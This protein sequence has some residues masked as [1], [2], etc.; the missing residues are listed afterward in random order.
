MP[1]IGITCSN[2]SSWPSSKA[3]S[4]RRSVAACTTD[5]TATSDGGALHS[6]GMTQLS[7]IEPATDSGVFV[8][9]TANGSRYVVV[10]VD[11]RWWV[12]RSPALGAPPLWLDKG[13]GINRLEAQVGLPLR[14]TRSGGYLDG[15]VW[16]VGGEIEGIATALPGDLNEAE[17]RFA[18]DAG[19]FS[20]RTGLAQ[21]RPSDDP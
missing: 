5:A 15:D 21:R 12:R 2:S 14:C 3:A 19:A 6:G 1:L 17:L 4:T 13:S 16:A 9:T 18:I 7:V 11:R 8:V 20:A 10:G